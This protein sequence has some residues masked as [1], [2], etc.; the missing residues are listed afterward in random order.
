MQS[1]NSCPPGLAKHPSGAGIADYLA[2]L[3]RLSPQNLRG[4]DI[5]MSAR[6]S[7]LIATAQDTYSVPSDQDL[8]IY[9]ISGWYRSSDLSTEAIINAIFT[10]FS[11]SELQI[12]RMQNCSVQLENKDR[13]LPVWDKA[14]GPLSAIT[15]PC[16][17][18][19]VFPVQAPLLVPRS[20]TLR[21]TFTLNSVAAAVAGNPADYGLSIGGI[22]IPT[23][24]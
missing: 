2:E 17:T 18:P 23:R 10:S 1:P 13:N 14:A 4:V 20:H 12:A 8:V 9:S 21:A 11:P 22:L 15:P 24:N 16:G 6:L 5:S 7:P 3:L 19:L